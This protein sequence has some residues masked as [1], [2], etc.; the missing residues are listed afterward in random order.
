CATAQ[1]NRN[2]PVIEVARPFWP[3]ISRRQA[4]PAVSLSS[5][6]GSVRRAPASRSPQPCAS[7]PVTAHPCS[8]CRH[9]TS[10]H[11]SATAACSHRLPAGDAGC[12][13]VPSGDLHSTARASHPPVYPSHPTASLPAAP[14]KASWDPDSSAPSDPDSSRSSGPDS[15]APAPRRCLCPNRRPP[16]APQHTTPPLEV[17]DCSPRIAT[18]VLLTARPQQNR[19]GLFIEA[20]NPF[21]QTSPPQRGPPRR[22]PAQFF[23]RLCTS[24]ASFSIS[25]ALRIT[26]TDSSSLLALST[27]DFSSLDSANS[28]STSAESFL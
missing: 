1:R 3:E 7:H 11:S 27:S 5:S 19:N 20:L 6:S 9:R 21:D 28:L 23:I 12:R 25:A 8:S 2:G 17:P 4:P 24:C 15:S 13:S 18:R 16:S 26:S 14:P 22:R 10:A